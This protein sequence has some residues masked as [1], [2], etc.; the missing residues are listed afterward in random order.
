MLEEAAKTELDRL[1]EACLQN[2]LGAVETMYPAC[3]CD[4]SQGDPCRSNLKKLARDGDGR[5]RRRAAESRTRLSLLV[6]ARQLRQLTVKPGQVRSSPEESSRVRAL[7]GRVVLS[8]PS[9]RGPASSGLDRQGRPGTGRRRRR[10]IHGLDGAKANR[11]Q[12]KLRAD[13]RGSVLRRLL[14][15]LPKVDV[16]HEANLPHASRDEK[17][18]RS[19]LFHVRKQICWDTTPRRRS[20]QQSAEPHLL[21]VGQERPQLSRRSCEGKSRRRRG[22]AGRDLNSSGLDE[23]TKMPLLI[24]VSFFCPSC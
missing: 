13:D 14:Q 24:A 21:G 16:F 9:R 18:L 4:Q 23:E 7:S 17:H 2:R 8:R 11:W 12:G 15:H 10:G 6:E 22:R 5:E 20:A 3:A 1:L 19:F